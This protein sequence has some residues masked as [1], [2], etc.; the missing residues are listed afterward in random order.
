[1]LIYDADGTHS[2]SGAVGISVAGAGQN[3]KT[4]DLAAGPNLKTGDF[5]VAGLFAGLFFS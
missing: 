4:G 5:A 3:F 1:M 2:G